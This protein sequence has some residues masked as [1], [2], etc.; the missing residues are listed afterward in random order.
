MTQDSGLAGVTFV[1]QPIDPAAAT[2]DALVEAPLVIDAIDKRF[3][4]IDVLGPLALLGLFVGFWYWMHLWALENLFNRDGFLMPAPH[5]I[6]DES[7]IH[8]REQ[9]SGEAFNPRGDMLRALLETTKLTFV[10]LGCSI[11]L[12]TALAMLMTP[13]RWLERSVYPYLVA[14]QAVPI[15][16]IAPV[17]GAVFDYTFRTRV[18]VVV[19]ISIVPI[20]TNTLFGL[21]S[22]EQGQ[23]ELFTL[24]EAGWRQRLFKLQFPAALPAIFTGYR[25]SAGLAV[26]GAVVGELFNRK[27][28]Q[29]IGIVMDEYR[30]RNQFTFT[31]GALLLSSLLGIAVY[32]AFGAVQKLVIGKWYQQTAS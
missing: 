6:I 13:F 30:S 31:Y 20:I 16:V 14:L 1:D 12:G 18:I 19:M 17:L 27:G 3:R 24:Q 21:R 29:G 15:L 28:A 23:H 22:A 11:L 26:I 25:I 8:G 2:D 5:R 7:F 9:P 4:P 10:G 32:F